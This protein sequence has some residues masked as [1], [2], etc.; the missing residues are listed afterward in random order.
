MP[1]GPLPSR[2]R[3]PR[4]LSL[5]EPNLTYNVTQLIATFL[6]LFVREGPK[7]RLVSFPYSC[8]TLQSV[9]VVIS[10][11]FVAYILC[12]KSVYLQVLQNAI[13]L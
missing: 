7:R 11:A 1:L 4:R 13:Y 3:V 2:R 5:L 6:T 9:A 12:I 8:T 10:Y